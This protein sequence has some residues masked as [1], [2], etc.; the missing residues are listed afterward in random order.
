M[1][2]VECPML[3]SIHLN[4]IDHLRT[5]LPG[6]S[7]ESNPYMEQTLEILDFYGIEKSDFE[8]N[9]NELR[10]TLNVKKAN[11][12]KQKVKDHCVKFKSIQRY[13]KEH[14]NSLQKVT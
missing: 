2:L 4:D 6:E 3:L 13:Q 1:G 5:I 10:T 8:C 12:L 14:G 11:I 9:M 7:Q